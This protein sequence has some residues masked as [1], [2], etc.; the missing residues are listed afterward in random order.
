MIISNQNCFNIVINPTNGNEMGG[1]L[2]STEHSDHNVLFS[3]AMIIPFLLIPMQSAQL[4][5]HE[6]M[7][8]I[9]LM[10]KLG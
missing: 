6:D 10:W 8:S 3:S 7:Q 4:C 5:W 9:L 1:I 2:K